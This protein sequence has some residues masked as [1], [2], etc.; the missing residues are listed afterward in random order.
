MSTVTAPTT[1]IE[2]AGASSLEAGRRPVTCGDG[3]EV[4]P[5]VGPKMAQKTG[6]KMDRPPPG[7]R[8]P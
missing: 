7:Q 6:Q 2:V 4:G 3:P 5:E 1:V 8:Q